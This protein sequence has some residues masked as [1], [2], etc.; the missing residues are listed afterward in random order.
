MINVPLGRL[1]GAALVAALASGYPRGVPLLI[2]GYPRGVPLL[3]YVGTEA[4]QV[5]D[6]GDDLLIFICLYAALF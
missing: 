2:S 4:L 5:G 3:F 1:V 6:Q